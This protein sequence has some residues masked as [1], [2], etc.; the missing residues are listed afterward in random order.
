MLQ[1]AKVATPATAAFGLSVQ[2]MVAPTGIAS[3]T[4]LVAVVTVLPPASWIVT[5]G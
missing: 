3:V 4:E 5:T 1:P 2:A